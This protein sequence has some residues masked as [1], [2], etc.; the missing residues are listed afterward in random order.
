MSQPAGE[1]MVE[2]ATEHNLPIRH[3]D[4]AGAAHIRQPDVMS[5]D[6]FDQ[7]VSFE[8]LSRVLKNLPEGIVEVGCHPGYPADLDEA[9]KEP[10]ET[11][12][13]LL[14]DPRIKAIIEEEG[15]QLIKFSNL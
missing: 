1:V 13:R 4:Y 2:L 14:T 5:L 6:F 3:H 9:Y 7:T 15:I 12:L 8:T 10:R 11:E